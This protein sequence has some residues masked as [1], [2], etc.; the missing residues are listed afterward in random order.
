METIRADIQNIHF[1]LFG[2]YLD[3]K[4][5]NY[6]ANC[7]YNNLKTVDDITQVFLKSDEYVSKVT[8]TFRCEWDR[9]M[10]GG[11]HGLEPELEA[12]RAT[13]GCR[14][15]DVT[16]FI[17]RSQAYR[18]RHW[19]MIENEYSVITG[20]ACPEST[21]EFYLH[22]FTEYDAYTLSQLCQDITTKAHVLLCSHEN[23]PVPCD[24]E[25]V[26]AEAEDSGEADSFGKAFKDAF[27]RYPVLQD[28]DNMK[29]A[30]TLEY[31]AIDA[32]ESVFRRPMSVHEYHKYIVINSLRTESEFH[33]VR[34]VQDAQYEKI[35]DIFR[36]YTGVEISEYD[37]F[38]KQHLQYVDDDEYYVMLAERIIESKEYNEGMKCMLGR[39]YHS[40]FDEHLEPQD[41]DY[42]FDIVKRQRLSIQSPE[43]SGILTTFKYETDDIVSRIF[44]KFVLV[45]ERQPDMYEVEQHI[46]MYRRCGEAYSAVD[47]QLES[48]LM[49]SLEFH[50]VIKKKIRTHFKDMKGKEVTPSVMFEVLHTIIDTAAFDNMQHMDEVIHHEVCKYC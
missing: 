16:A 26:A 23:Q 44:S 39:T 37:S 22:K 48:R 40:L 32:F 14:E 29:R 27:G 34:V 1:S 9:L 4:T 47:S 30:T 43:I 35:R 18:D 19:N 41:L 31:S 21:V 13:T 33:S 7:V 24:D 8:S 6:W 25:E 38:C 12:F 36:I 42:I 28:V 11:T 50:D 20:C 10:G 3:S 46:G 5:L 49:K 2:S 15:E 17:K 45:F